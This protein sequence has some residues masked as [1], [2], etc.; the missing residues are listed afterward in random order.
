[1]ISNQHHRT[2]LWHLHGCAGVGGD[3]RSFPPPRP[4]CVAHV[5]AS[6]SGGLHNQGKAFTVQGQEG[7]EAGEWTFPSYVLQSGLC[8]L[9]G[10][11][12]PCMCRE[13]KSLPVLPRQLCNSVLLLLKR[14]P[15]RFGPILAMNTMAQ[16]KL[17]QYLAAG[18]WIIG[19]NKLVCRNC[20]VLVIKWSTLA[21]QEMEWLHP[22]PK[23]LSSR[24]GTKPQNWEVNP[25]CHRVTISVTPSPFLGLGW[26]CSHVTLG[27]PFTGLLNIDWNM[28]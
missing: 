11:S 9:A 15:G 13:A 28:Y 3:A 17:L 12:C 7:D 16:R 23:P 25:A 26:L 14:V 10:A 22:A 27:F 6:H 21:K 20:I 24:D 18:W 2:I 8:T 19:E 5:R 4:L 1:M